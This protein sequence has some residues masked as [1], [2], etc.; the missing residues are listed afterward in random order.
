MNQLAYVNSLKSIRSAI[1]SM[2]MEND[3][4]SGVT[5]QELANLLKL[6]SISKG[7]YQSLINKSDKAFTEEFNNIALRFTNDYNQK[8]KEIKKLPSYLSLPKLSKL[9][10]QAQSQLKTLSKSKAII[11]NSDE[12]NRQTDMI[13]RFKVSFITVG[14]ILIIISLLFIML[15]YKSSAFQEIQEALKNYDW[16][17]LFALIKAT[18]VFGILMLPAVLGISM[19]LPWVY[20]IKND[21]L[22][23]IVE[24]LNSFTFPVAEKIIGV[25]LV[26]LKLD[27]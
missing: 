22:R 2:L 24:F 8:I 16:K 4:W 14:S 27:K 17:R 12:L 15:Y 11:V 10:P 23:Q 6:G 9:L 3:S 7:E 21:T 19:I 1:G 25:V 20:E 13:R 26:A 5:V 18:L